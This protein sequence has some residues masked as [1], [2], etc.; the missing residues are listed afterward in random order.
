M[1]AST[2]HFNPELEVVFLGASPEELAVIA[3]MP[4]DPSREVIGVWFWELPA[5]YSQR[6]SIYYLNHTLYMDTK[7]L[8]GSGSTE[9]LV[10]KASSRGRRFE[11][12]DPSYGEYFL[13]DSQ[14][15]LHLGDEDGLFETLQKI[16]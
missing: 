14:G 13:L 12:K 9:E 6:I 8:D 2:T 7:F 11:E 15:N 3:N 1:K 16:K 10:E 5:E 4:I